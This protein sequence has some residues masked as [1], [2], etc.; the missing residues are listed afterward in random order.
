MKKFFILLSMVLTII[1]A[2]TLYS[3]TGYAEEDRAGKVDKVEYYLK[4]ITSGSYTER[5]TAA[6]EIT[7]SG[8]ND[9][10][11][12]KV[13]EERLL[14]GYQEDS[15][16]REHLDEMAWLCKALAS[17][18]ISDYKKTLQTVAQTASNKKLKG[19]AKQSHD[20]VD[21][22]AERNAIL[23]DT[24]YAE[25]GQSPEVTRLI[26]MLKSD[27]LTLKENAAKEISRSKQDNPKVFEVIEEELLKG[28]QL[29]SGNKNYVDTMAWLC[30][31]LGSSGDLKYRPTLQKIFDTTPNQT[32]R[33]YAEKSLRILK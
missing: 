32:L 17:S 18:G 9:P 30:K 28:Y 4:M 2:H 10:K 13:I 20:M 25:P 21:E 15:T 5:L 23:A 7:N 31:A 24:K 16:N 33:N 12:F 11:L 26:T 14:Q 29:N 1:M 27:N 8:L 6:K 19:Y 22:Y 3:K